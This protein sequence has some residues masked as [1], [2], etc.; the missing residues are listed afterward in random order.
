MDDQPKDQVTGLLAAWQQ[1]DESALDRLSPYVYEELKRLAS[2]AMAGEAAGHTLQTTALVHEAFV[3]LVDADVDYSGRQHFFALAAR[4]MRRILVDHARGKR[5]EKR[6]RGEPLLSLDVGEQRAADGGD[7]PETASLLELDDA[8]T[9][10]ADF[11][12]RSAEI[13]ELTFFGG[14][15]Y[16]EV[17]GLVGISRTAVYQDLKFARAWLRK[18]MS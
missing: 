5:R 12:P 13:V 2:N 1:G 11:D 7:G 15:S 14:L 6:G 8:L 18:A 3:R 9:K 4:M 10:L 17:A 16:D